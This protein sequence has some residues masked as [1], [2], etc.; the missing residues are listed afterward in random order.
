MKQIILS[1]LISLLGT[2]I[3]FAQWSFQGELTLEGRAFK[4]DNIELSED[5]GLALYS[6]AEATYK[7]N[8]FTQYENLLMK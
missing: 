1:I 4:N 8:K 2:E 7:N 6:R 3:V 5:K